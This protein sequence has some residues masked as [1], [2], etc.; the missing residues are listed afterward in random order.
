[1]LH[2][3]IARIHTLSFLI[4]LSWWN[5]ERYCTTSYTEYTHYMLW[6]V[7]LLWTYNFM[8]LDEQ[9][10][11]KQNQWLSCH[12]PW[13]QLRSGQRTSGLPTWASA[14]QCSG[15]CRACTRDRRLV[16]DVLDA[17][18]TRASAG[19]QLWKLSLSVRAHSKYVA[20]PALV[21]GIFGNR[22]ANDNFALSASRLPTVWP[23]FNVGCNLGSTRKFPTAAIDCPH[24]SKICNCIKYTL[25]LSNQIILLQ[26][27][28]D[29]DK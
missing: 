18:K 21:P 22:A 27:Q 19:N 4:T 20:T 6:V 25:D 23:R 7:Y 24:F 14:R 10:S 16:A 17:F 1:M 8:I 28:G 11:A 26:S 12:P 15:K 2:F 5:L 29:G 13:A 9:A 3:S